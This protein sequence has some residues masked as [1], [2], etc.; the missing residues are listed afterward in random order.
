MTLQELEQTCDTLSE[1][2]SNLKAALGTPQAQEIKDLLNSRRWGTADELRLFM[3][4]FGRES[5]AAEIPAAENS[6]QRTLK[7][8]FFNLSELLKQP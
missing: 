2:L 5:S 8:G 1:C 3:D 6:D 7:K 4:V